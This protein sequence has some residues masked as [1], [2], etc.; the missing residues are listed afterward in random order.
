MESYT[1]QCRE[2]NKFHEVQCI[3]FI[4]WYKADRKNKTRSKPS[5]WLDLTHVIRPTN[6]VTS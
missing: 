5:I 6:G 2:L 1:W 4:S 3:L